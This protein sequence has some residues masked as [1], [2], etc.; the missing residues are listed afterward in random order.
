MP[1]DVGVE[2]CAVVWPYGV[3]RTAWAIAHMHPINSR[4]TATTTWL[5]CFPRTIS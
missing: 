4:A 1:S 3:T 5:A 2:S